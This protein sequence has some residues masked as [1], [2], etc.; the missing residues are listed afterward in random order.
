MIFCSDKIP[1]IFYKDF[2]KL[3][4]YNNIRVCKSHTFWCY[5][6]LCRSG[7]LSITPESLIVTN[8]ELAITTGYFLMI[9]CKL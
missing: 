2:F 5:A 7:L 6:K 9:N 4:T 8:F 3:C 1:E